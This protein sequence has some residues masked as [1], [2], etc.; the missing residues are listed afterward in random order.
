MSK[1]YSIKPVGEVLKQAGLVSAEQVEIALKTQQEQGNRRLGE[2]LVL[3]GWLKQET[4]DFFAEEWWSLLN[5]KQKKPLGYYFEKAGLL[6]A[7]QIRDILNEQKQKAILFGELAI[8]KGWITPVT[9]NFFLQHL[10]SALSLADEPEQLNTLRP[11]DK[12]RLKLLELEGKATYPHLVLKEV[13]SWT[14]GHPFFTQKLCQLI[15]DSNKI[16]PS[17]MEADAVA[18]LVQARLVNNWQSQEGHE[19][20]KEISTRLLGNKQC[21]PILLLRLYKEILQQGEVRANQREKEDVLLNLGLV[22]K[23]QNK[24][25]V[26]NRIYQSV[27][28]MRWVDQQLATFQKREKKEIEITKKAKPSRI[29]SPNTNEPLTQLGSV[30]TLLGLLIVPPLLIRLNSGSVPPKQSTSP[31]LALQS[32][33]PSSLATLC[34][35]EIPSDVVDQDNLRTRL[36]NENQKLKESFPPTC[37]SL[38]YKLWG[39]SAPTL[40]KYNQVIEAVSNLCRIPDKADN[41]N[42]A[43]F[44]INYWYDSQ[45]WGQK[46]KAYLLLT[47]DC[48]AAE[49]HFP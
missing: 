13:L 46:V 15:C 16:I 3:Q 2:I 41:F 33:S 30:I 48:P 21:H 44:W 19:L 42:Q 38:L 11:F 28:D 17:G 18:Q 20:L 12:L 45:D 31:T 27:F 25:R 39:M 35:S 7:A 49:D 6:D 5:Q 40:G 34:Q 43:K 1:N 23:H 24:L 14:G 29:S 37:K 9:L 22:V 26:S 4:A 8:K 36:E 10:Y 32:S 47:P